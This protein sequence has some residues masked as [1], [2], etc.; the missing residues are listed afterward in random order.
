MVK[1]KGFKF[2]KR[3]IW[4][5]GGIVAL[6]LVAVFVFGI[7][8][9]L[10]PFSQPT[11]IPYPDLRNVNPSPEVAIPLIIENTKAT[12]EEDNET[13]IPDLPII[14]D[15]ELEKIEMAMNNTESSNKTNTEQ[16]IDKLFPKTIKLEGNIIKIDNNGTKYPETFSVDLPALTLFIEDITNID[17]SGGFIELDMSIVADPNVML[18]ADGIFD[19]LVNNQTI[20]TQDVRLV[21]QGTTDS[22]GKISL[23]FGSATM[24]TFDFNSNFDKF[25][26]ESLTKLS[27]V[28]KSLEITINNSEKFGIGNEEFF[29]MSIFRDEFKVLIIDSEGNQI[30]SYPDDSLITITSDP[31]NL[32]YRCSKRT[33]CPTSGYTRGCGWLWKTVPAISLGSIKVFDESGQIIDAGAGTGLALNTK[34]FRNQNYTIDHSLIDK[35]QSLDPFDVLTPKTQQNF[36]YKVWTSVEYGPKTFSTGTS[37]LCTVTTTYQA[38]IAGT[39]FVTSN[40]PK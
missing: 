23:S 40:F 3:F 7:G 9:D 1:K 4:I 34:L 28:I 31:S 20:F 19:V 27:F 32:S 17:F 16:I 38:P 37:G 14:K 26:N 8:F 5:P 35:P 18:V 13:I 33:Q 39:E 30:I 2:H 12:L 11:S 22:D 25:P 21:A 29:T 36:Q 10:L 6:V 24:Y 15:D